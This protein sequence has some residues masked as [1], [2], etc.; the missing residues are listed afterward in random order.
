[1]S[2]G[3]PYKITGMTEPELNETFGHASFKQLD[4][5]PGFKRAFAYWQGVTAP[6]TEACHR[7]SIITAED[8]SIIVY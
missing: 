4:N 1:M 2:T 8:L 5:S 6:L 3:E 7:A